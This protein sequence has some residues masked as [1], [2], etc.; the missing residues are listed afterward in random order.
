MNKRQVST[1][2]L[3]SQERI[4]M[5]MSIALYIFLSTMIILALTCFLY[6]Y[7]NLTYIILLYNCIKKSPHLRIK[8]F[9]D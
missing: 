1:T 8:T 9:R 3:A 4:R 6:M 2:T 7:V 5:I